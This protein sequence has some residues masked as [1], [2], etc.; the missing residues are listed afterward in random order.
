MHR[1]T[2]C[3]SVPRTATSLSE[4]LDTS[5]GHLTTNQ[6]EHGTKTGTIIHALSH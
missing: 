5:Y 2:G 3:Q 1:K 4:F 6:Q